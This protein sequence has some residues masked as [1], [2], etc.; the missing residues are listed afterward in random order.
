MSEQKIIEYGAQSTKNI[1][2]VKLKEKKE[3]EELVKSLSWTNNCD[4]ELVLENNCDNYPYK[5]LCKNCPDPKWYLSIDNITVLDKL[6]H[7]ENVVFMQR[8]Y[9]YDTKLFATYSKK[10]L[11]EFLNVVEFKSLKYDKITLELLEVAKQ[12]SLSY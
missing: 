2:D 6:N 8:C 10:S 5:I 7:Y 11:I 3:Y 9:M 12:R 1:N 4:A